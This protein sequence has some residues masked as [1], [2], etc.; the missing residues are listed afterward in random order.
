M[1]NTYFGSVTSGRLL[2][3]PFVGYII[4]LNVVF[5]ALML[6]GA[7]SLGVAENMAGGDLTQAQQMLSE[8]FGIPAMIIIAIVIFGVFFA[9]LNLKAKRIRDMGLPGWKTLLAVWAA[10]IVIAIIVSMVFGANTG[11]TEQITSIVSSIAILALI[12]IPSNTFNKTTI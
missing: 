8:K 5:I 10:L 6:G 1:F 9:T 11:T 3:L 4:L 7:A 2:R 12:F